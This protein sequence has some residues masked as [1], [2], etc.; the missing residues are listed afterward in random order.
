MA[1]GSTED[2]GFTED[3]DSTGGQDSTAHR[4][5]MGRMLGHVRSGHMWEAQGLADFTVAVSME[6]DS[7]VAMAAE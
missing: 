7:L 6:A 2:Q 3:Q 5:P 1:R 4:M